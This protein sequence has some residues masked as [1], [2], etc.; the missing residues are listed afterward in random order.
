MGR[1]SDLILQGTFDWRELALLDNWFWD[2]VL[3]VRFLGIK[4]TAT[5]SMK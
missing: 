2:I 5:G 3:G 1:I 4:V